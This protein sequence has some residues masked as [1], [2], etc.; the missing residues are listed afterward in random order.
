MVTVG[1]VASVSVTVSCALPVCPASV[2]RHLL[3]YGVEE[4]LIECL[5]LRK[6]RVHKER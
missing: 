2:A 1:A 6:T 5:R 3:P 4:P